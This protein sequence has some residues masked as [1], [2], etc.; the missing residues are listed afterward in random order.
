MQAGA[1]ELANR[2]NEEAGSLIDEATQKLG[3]K[4]GDDV[5]GALKGLLPG[6]KKE[7][8]KGGGG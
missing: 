7:D 8:D 1:N 5:T 6:G 2:V 3:D 4:L